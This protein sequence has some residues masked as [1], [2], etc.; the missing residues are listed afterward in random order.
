[1]IEENHK[2]EK[3]DNEKIDGKKGSEKI[4]K[5]NTVGNNLSGNLKI[6]E[7]KKIIG[8]QEISKNDETKE[9]LRTNQLL[10]DKN[11]KINIIN[12]KTKKSKKR[13]LTIDEYEKKIKENIFITKICFIISISINFIDILIIIIFPSIFLDIFNI[14]CLILITI[15]FIIILIKYILKRIIITSSY[16]NK[17][18]KILIYISIIIGI[19]FCNIL[20]IMIHKIM[21]NSVKN[22]DIYQ[23]FLGIILIFCYSII[24]ISAPIMILIKLGEIKNQ[25]QKIGLLRNQN[26][27][28]ISGNSSI[29]NDI[30]SIQPK[31]K[32]YVVKSFNNSFSINPQLKENNK[33][34]KI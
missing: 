5:K 23:I 1:M 30:F 3:I 13:K 12:S 9:N 31:E 17:T 6:G 14:I 7:I 29:Q 4:N 18:K 33:N 2:K 28:N 24:N 16:Y 11:I 34:N 10:N 22:F 32:S 8:G 20:Y 26:S 15:S 21:L 27:L 25:I 19:Y